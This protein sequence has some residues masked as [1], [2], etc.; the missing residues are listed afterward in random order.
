MR[1]LFT[2]FGVR[3]VGINFGGFK[4]IVPPGLPGLFLDLL[5]L[6]AGE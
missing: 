3:E 5:L 1:Y 4:R 6:Q 2:A